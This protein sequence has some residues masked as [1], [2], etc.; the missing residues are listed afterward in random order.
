MLIEISA[1][2]EFGDNFTFHFDGKKKLI[3]DNDEVNLGNLY[4]I[5]FLLM[6][7]YG[8]ELE[9]NDGI[10]EFYEI[11]KVDYIADDEWVITEDELI[12]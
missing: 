9:D 3:I 8:V 7:K 2:T 1:K 4:Q 11:K 12:A 6:G 5:W 10:E